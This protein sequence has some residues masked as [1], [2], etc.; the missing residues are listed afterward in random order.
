MQ[1]SKRPELHIATLGD[2]RADYTTPYTWEAVTDI[3]C[4]RVLLVRSAQL[5]DP[6][7]SELKAFSE[8][9]HGVSPI[10]SDYLILDEEGNV[11]ASR[12][13]SGKETVQASGSREVLTPPTD[14][15]I[16][17][18][19]PFEQLVALLEHQGIWF[20]RG[21]RFDDPFEGAIS[22]KTIEER[23]RLVRN[24]AQEP[25]ES[26]SNVSASNLYFYARKWVYINCWHA[27]EVESD[28]MWRQY[29]QP[30]TVCVQSTV[31]KLGRCLG[32]TVKL[33]EVEY[34]DP[35]KESVPFTN[36]LVPFEYKRKSFEHEREIR[37]LTFRDP[38]AP[39]QDGFYVQ[40][41][42]EEV[43]E[44]VYVRPTSK[45]WFYQLVK[46]I[47]DERH[48]LKAIEILHSDLEEP[49]GFLER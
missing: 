1:L 31:K 27:N 4:F 40:V 48:G 29:A 14:T 10:E 6:Q 30:H 34:I 15:K 22:E 36:V 42:L 37:A 32:P 11:I 47:L 38:L 26:P 24:S 13:I 12:L 3:P 5:A 7:H 44:R 45:P 21:D 25:K 19:M 33:C 28:A 41:K 39:E 17:K 9:L 2:G 8:Y 23:F 18:Y 20:S 16:W 43:I 49:P 35:S 46:R